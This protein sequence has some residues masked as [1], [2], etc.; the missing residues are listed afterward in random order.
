VDLEKDRVLFD[1]GDVIRYVDFPHNAVV[2]FVVGFEAGDGVEVAIVGRDGIVGA[3]AEL[4]ET[5]VLANAIVLLAGKTSAIEAGR[6]R[7]A[8]DGSA[9]LRES[10]L[11]QGQAVCVQAQQMAA[12]N[13]SHTVEA[14][15]ARWLL[16]I[17]DLVGS[18]QFTLTQ[19]RMAQMIGARRNSVSI[20]A[21]TLMEAGCIRYSRGHI[22]IINLNVLG[23]VGCECYAAVN[24]QNHRLRLPIPGTLQQELS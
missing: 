22:E 17:R 6:L 1:L 11:S 16:R 2:S 4:G 15:L 8:A 12:C 3:L 21:H 20:V 5:V 19:E 9:S 23:K 24:A 14:R 7:A 18:D 10:L 13:A